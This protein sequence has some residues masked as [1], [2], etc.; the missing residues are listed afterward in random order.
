M[1]DSGRVWLCVG[2]PL[3]YLPVLTDFYLIPKHKYLGTQGINDSPF[4]NIFL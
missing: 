4:F 1:V 2:L 3:A